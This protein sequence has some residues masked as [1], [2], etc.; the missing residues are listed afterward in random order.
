MLGLWKGCGY[1]LDSGLRHLESEPV[2]Q[3]VPGWNLKYEDRQANPTTFG[4]SG[5][6]SIARK[7]TAPVSQAKAQKQLLERYGPTY[8]QPMNVQTIAGVTRFNWVTR[9]RG[10]DI[11]V[12]LGRTT[13]SV[14]SIGI[15]VVEQ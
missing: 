3:G 8:G 13:G 7:W 14:T 15:T 4:G 2:L 9:D 1:I 6:A 12:G 11:L 5:K 10:A